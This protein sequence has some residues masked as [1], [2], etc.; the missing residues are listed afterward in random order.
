MR[1]VCAGGKCAYEPAPR[2]RAASP[3]PQGRNAPGRMARMGRERTSC[4]AGGAAPGFAPKVPPATESCGGTFS[5]HPEWFV[6]ISA[7]MGACD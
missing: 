6:Y 3:T 2:V 1:A 5:G 7:F 4:S